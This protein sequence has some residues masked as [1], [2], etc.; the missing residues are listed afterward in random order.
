MKQLT[1][2]LTI[3]LLYVLAFEVM[4]FSSSAQAQTST[5]AHEADTAFG[6][7]L[8]D[9]WDRDKLTGDWLGLRS[10]LSKHGIDIGLRLTQYWQSVESGG[11]NQSSEYGG[12]M[13][14]RVN[15][16]MHK[17]LGTW[18]GFSVNMHARTRFGYDI[19]ADAGAFAL[20]NAGMLM[21]GAGKYHDTDVTGLTVSQYLPFFGG[22]A[23]LT[24]GMF[25]VIDTVTGFF[26]HLGYGQEG[27]WNANGLLTVLP[28]VGSIQGLSLY[29]AIGVTVN[30]K[31]KIPQSGLI[32]L[33]TENESQGMYSV[34]D[35][36]DDGVFLAGFHR[37]I[38]ELDD[39]M[40]YFMVFAGGS[41]RDQPSNEKHDF[42]FVP[43]QGIEN[44]EEHKPWDI[45]AYFYQDFWQ[46]KSNPER[47]MT[48][49]SGGTWGPDNPQFARWHIFASV[50]GFGLI[51]SRPHDRMGVNGWYN[52]LSN[53]FVSLVSTVD[54]R[55][56]DLWGLE[57][58]YNFEINKWLHLTG[59]FQLVKNQNTRD[60]IA[61]IPGFRL[62]VDF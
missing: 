29:G 30:E 61:V 48:F 52:G 24:V 5:H 47:K 46:D 8:K 9:V 7:Y 34:H 39:K 51:C 49:F 45:A 31:H 1:S 58:Y 53:E 55:L 3:V 14:Y 59:D 42:I 35:A 11:V 23:N 62:V 13:D 40:G 16:D 36:F 21:P 50:E 20:Q 54:I 44:T 12:T 28:W 43:G 15:L 32:A 19:N 38:W 10:D 6:R 33:G 56:R 27:F 26:P 60:D 17:L 57:A 18:E 22:L 37:F 4:G 2:I 41:T 25:D